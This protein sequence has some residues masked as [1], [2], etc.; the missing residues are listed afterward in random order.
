LVPLVE[1]G[2]LASPETKGILEKYL[3]YF[4]E[5]KI[6]TLVLGCT[7]YPLLKKNIMKIL[8]K[9]KVIDSA[10]EIA[11]DTANFLEAR[12]LGAVLYNKGESAFYVTDNPERFNKVGKTFLKKEMIPAK[13]V[14][15]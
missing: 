7:H 1:E 6:D 13:L 10:I 3:L 9:V 12:G 14:K 2:R 5:K 4:K 8:P 11:K 15:F